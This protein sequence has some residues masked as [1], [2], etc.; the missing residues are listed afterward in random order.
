[1][2]EVVSE[3]ALEGDGRGTGSGTW[4]LGPIGRCVWQ[5]M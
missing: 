4:K 1:M 3:L 2:A 5:E